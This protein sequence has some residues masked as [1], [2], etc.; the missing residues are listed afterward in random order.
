MDEIVVSTVVYLPTEDVY[1]FLVDFPR[2]ANYSK[3]L[4]DVTQRGDGGSGT[5]YALHFSWWKLTY[6]AHSEVTELEP[7]NRIEWQIVKDI[8]AHGRWRVEALDTLPDA[9]PNDAETAC[10]VFFEVS[11]DADSADKD[12]INLP[13]FVSFGW[14]ID[15]LKPALQTEA[16]RIVERIVEDLE[17]RRRSVELTVERRTV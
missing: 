4:Q 16:E 11:Y 15:K 13:R 2:Y 10:R 17:G 1:D 3:H 8:H 6:T 9:A 7:P 12:S 5:R 14:V